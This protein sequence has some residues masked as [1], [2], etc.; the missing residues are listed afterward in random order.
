MGQPEKAA[1]LRAGGKQAKLADF[2]LSTAQTNHLNELANQKIADRAN[3]NGGD[4]FKTQADILT[5]T[6]VGG[7]AGAK[8][9]PRISADGKTVQIVLT[10]PDGTEQVVRQY[11]NDDQ[12]QMRAQQDLMQVNPTVKLQWLHERATTDQKTKL[13]ESVIGENKAKTNFYNSFADQKESLANGGKTDKPY[14][15]N[16]DD[17]ILFNSVNSSVQD[18]DKGVADAMGKLMPGDDPTKAPGVQYAKQRLTQA[19]LNQ[20]K[21]HINLGVIQPEQLA[22]DIMGNAKNTAEVR[23]SLNQLIPVAGPEFTDKVASLVLQ[24]DAYIAMSPKPASTP[25]P[26]PKPAETIT[27]EANPTD[28]R[29]SLADSTNKKA[30]PQ[31]LDARANALY[32]AAKTVGEKIDKD[33]DLK[34]LKDESARL[35]K[36]GNSKASRAKFSEYNQLKKQKYGV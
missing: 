17:K 8:A 7:M 2:Q 34:A 16:E 30:T 14:K 27:P 19:K 13:D 20:L 32:Q 5:E 11:G 33:L 28:K 4:W 10:R 1:A 21:T 25:N 36:S 23:A 31:S 22:N 15:M 26:A 6:G 9:A 18:A 3:T 35:L 12:G 24:N 29:P